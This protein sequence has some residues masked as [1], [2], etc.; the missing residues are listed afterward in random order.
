MFRRML[1]GATLLI[2]LAAAPAAAQYPF[3]V[4]PGTVVAGGSVTVSGKGC[5]P[6]AP[7]TITMV[8][9]AAQKAVGDVIFETTITSD[10]NGEFTFTFTVPVGTPVGTYEVKAECNDGVVFSAFI[11]VV[12]STTAT[13]TPGTGSTGSSGPI[14]RT[15][16]DLN[17][18][19]LAGAG[20]ITV[21]GI[22][23]IATRSRRH[24]AQA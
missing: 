12:D 1:I 16:S 10:E 9:G 7:V 23:L 2:A 13:T 6:N 5:S 21:G 11:D 19:G 4:S 24:Q 20:L 15:G 8:E 3:N 14:V 17:G 18:L 22:I